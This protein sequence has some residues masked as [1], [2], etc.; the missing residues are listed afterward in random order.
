M[1]CKVRPYTKKSNLA[2]TRYPHLLLGAGCLA[3]H[4]VNCLMLLGSP[5]DMVHNPRL[6][7]THSSTQTTRVRL[8]WSDPQNGI[9]P[10]CSGFQVQGSANS[11]TSMALFYSSFICLYSITDFIRFCNSI[12]KIYKIIATYILFGRSHAAH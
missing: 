12:L 11:P 7:K 10:C 8:P 5:P 9:H 4:R 1:N 3:A 6:R 2:A